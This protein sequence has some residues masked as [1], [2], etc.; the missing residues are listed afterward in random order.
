MVTF[1]L[2][3]V[4]LS[5]SGISLSRMSS[6]AA[7]SSLSKLVRRSTR[8]KSSPYF[9]GIAGNV[10]R[11]TAT[12][13]FFASCT[14]STATSCDKEEEEC[15]MQRDVIKRKGSDIKVEKLASTPTKKSKTSPSKAKPSTTIERTQSFEPA[16]WGNI[17]VDR[18]HSHITEKTTNNSHGINVHASN[19]LNAPD[20]PPVH[21]LIL[22]THP[23]IASLSKNQFFGHPQNAFW[24]LVG[25]ALQF[26]RCDAV[27][28]STNKPYV[29]F[30]DHLR[31]GMDKIIDYDKQLEAL[32]SKG[33]ALWD[34]VQECERK[35]SL[36]ADINREVA[37]PIK[38]FCNGTMFHGAG[39]GVKRIVI[40]NGTTGASFFVKHFKQWFREGGIVAAE[41]EL[42]QRVF[43]SAMNSARNAS[44]KNGGYKRSG[45]VIQVVCLPGV[46][47]AA[48]KFSYT[49]KREAWERGC[50]T[51]GLADYNDWNKQFDFQSMTTPKK[52]RRTQKDEL[53]S[54][55]ASTLSSQKSLSSSP[56]KPPN[57]RILS[58]DIAALTPENE[59]VDLKVP[60]EELRPSATLT[61]GQCFN[62]LVVENDNEDDIADSPSKKSAWGTH[63]A[64]EWVGPLQNRVLS[65][66]ETPTTTLYRVL[67]G[68]TTGASDDLRA[69]FRLET[70]LAPLYE[71]WSNVD[72]RLAKIAA[73]IPGCRVLRQDPLE[74]MFSFICSSNNNIPR[75]TKMLSSFRQQYGN[76]MMAIPAQN[77]DDISLYSFP[78]LASLSHAAE[79]DLRNMG[80]GYR[81][82]YM[83]ETRDLL[84]K[85]GR[86]DFLLGLRTETNSQVVQ[87]SLIQFSG[88]GRKVADCIALFSLD[89][90]DA[91]PVDVHVQHIA[92]RDYDPNVL[93]SA[94]SI[95]PTIYKQVGDLF[96]TRFPSYAGWAHTLLF[97]AEL[98]SFRGVLPV[99]IVQEMDE[100]R[101]REQRRKQDL[102][103]RTD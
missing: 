92:S 58:S 11:Q 60:P 100:W 101:E 46:S 52:K 94:K 82:K 93:G 25:D 69:Y 43:K 91:I 16:W 41:D 74:C 57:I 70:P 95:T 31:Y 47:P 2:I 54:M 7:S 77:C 50:F 33:F 84:L 80:L 21:T 59:W 71:E 98:P 40:A 51:P 64:K 8:L 24:Y 99:D 36:D 23:S 73:V 81:A 103:K 48:A 10:K 6:P 12:S 97:V 45:R 56:S 79:A 61:N 49:E 75:I 102:K 66:R 29:Y 3:G 62:W 35:G 72:A 88:I 13:P 30:Y 39:R 15:S 89:Q 67:H 26:R 22:G 86:E 37:N 90:D 53:L 83:T 68:P 4:V 63:N 87:D 27:S 32:V 1:H 85:C 9:C 42:S 20:Y 28:P 38:E 17:L 18:T 34:I 14:E 19:E 5:V 76:F 65:I 55:S 78:T 96:R 44:V